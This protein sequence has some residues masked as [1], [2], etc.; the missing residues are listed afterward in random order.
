MPD[1][2]YEGFASAIG[3]AKAVAYGSYG[4]PAK[5]MASGG[6]PDAGDFGV[7]GVAASG[8]DRGEL[9]SKTGKKRPYVRVR[10]VRFVFA[11]RSY[12]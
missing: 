4:V 1:T 12:E 3:V 2:E 10:G 5:T 8:V 7:D 6:L 11:F 9:I